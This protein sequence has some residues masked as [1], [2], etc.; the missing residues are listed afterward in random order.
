MKKQK[1]YKYIGYNGI[2]T[3]PILLPDV[4][5][6]VVYELR[7]DNKCYLTDGENK[8]YS[9]IVLEEDVEHWQ[10]V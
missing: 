10:E 6:L 4:K 7:A 2:I 3:S 1:L 5:N 9:V 8:R